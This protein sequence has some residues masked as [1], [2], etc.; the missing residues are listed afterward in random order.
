FSTLVFLSACPGLAGAQTTLEVGKELKQKLAGGESH[1]Y[2]V[3]LEAG[4][5]ARIWV[6]QESIQ[7]SVT[8]LWGEKKLFEVTH[9]SIGSRES[10]EVIAEVSGDHRVVVAATDPTAPAG[11]YTITLRD[12]ETATERDREMAAGTLLHAQALTHWHDGS[13]E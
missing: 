5:F 1:E 4:Q 6:D 12:V 2:R 10:A 3:R 11:T 8:I 9:A 7:A 13:R